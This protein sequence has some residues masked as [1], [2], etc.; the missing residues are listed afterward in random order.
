MYPGATTHHLPDLPFADELRIFAEIGWPAVEVSSGRIAEIADAE[1][2]EA[3]AEAAAGAAEAIGIAM[4]QVHLL[5]AANLATADDAKREQDLAVA[6]REVELCARMGITAGVIHPGG[7]R[8]PTLAELEAERSRRIESFARLGTHA[9]HYGVSIAV[10][11]TYDKGPLDNAAHGQRRFGSIIPELLELIDA[12]G[13]PNLGVC[14][15]TGH[16]L[17]QG[18]SMAEAVRQCGELLI[19]THIDDNDGISDQ[20]ICPGYGKVDWA[21][22]VAALREI[23]YEGIFNIEIGGGG[24]NVPD[25]IRLPRL[26]YALQIANWLLAE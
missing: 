9:A 6:M 3:A 5:M 7:D 22:G 4:P 1:R 20:H 18:V 12:V 24:P 25:A 19:A 16:G 21:P 15:D 10:E 11:N 13:M 8:P 23:G 14:Y 17:L 2:P 26:R